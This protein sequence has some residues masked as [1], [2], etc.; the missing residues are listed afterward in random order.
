[1]MTKIEKLEK[2]SKSM[3]QPCPDR[4]RAAR[5]EPAA[6]NEGPTYWPKLDFVSPQLETLQKI[7]KLN[8]I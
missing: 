8:G 4:P 2:I 1:M 7:L 6:K 3:N 5:K